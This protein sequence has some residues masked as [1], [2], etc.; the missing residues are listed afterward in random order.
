MTLIIT[1][2]FNGGNHVFDVNFKSKIV[3]KLVAFLLLKSDDIVKIEIKD[4]KK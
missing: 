2:K 4:G 1:R 3:T